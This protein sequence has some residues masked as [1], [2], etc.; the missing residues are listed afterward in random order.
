M[1]EGWLLSCFLGRQGTKMSRDTLTNWAQTPKRTRGMYRISWSNIS[2]HVSWRLR[3]LSVP[4]QAL[5]CFYMIPIKV[6]LTLLIDSV[7]H[8]LKGY[9]RLLPI[10]L[11]WDYPLT[12]GGNRHMKQDIAAWNWRS[13]AERCLCNTMFAVATYRAS[14]CLATFKNALRQEWATGRSLHMDCTCQPALV[15]YPNNTSGLFAGASWLI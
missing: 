13:L 9:P 5:R 2:C 7:K 4:S 8:W 3:V 15:P 12:K 1:Q 10:W 14:E 6:G 11:D